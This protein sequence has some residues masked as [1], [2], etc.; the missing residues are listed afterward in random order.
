MRREIIIPPIPTI[1][2]VVWPV[3][4]FEGK[5]KTVV[6]KQFYSVDR[7]SGPELCVREHFYDCINRTKEKEV[8]YWNAM[9]MTEE[10]EY[11]VILME[12]ETYVRENRVNKIDGT[13][14]LLKKHGHI[15]VKRIRPTI[16]FIWI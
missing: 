15:I 3:E 13:H 14:W 7:D 6:F 5:E 4:F 12:V 16:E 9:S 11:N 8:R 1:V 2:D 10:I